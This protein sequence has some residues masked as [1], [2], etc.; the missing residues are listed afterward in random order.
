MKYFIVHRPIYGMSL[1]RSSA[2]NRLEHLSTPFYE[3]ICK[4]VLY[5]DSSGYYNH[6]VDD[7]LANWLTQVNNLTIKGN[8]KLKAK[9]YLNSFLRDFGD[10]YSDA[11]INLTAFALSNRGKYPAVRTDSYI[12]N[13]YE[14]SQSII[15]E[16]PSILASNNSLNQ[17]DF[18]NIL[19]DLLDYQCLNNR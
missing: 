14:V 7:E 10:D 4:C 1:D 8:K 12:T 9:D 18:I 3:H 5:G 16:L 19:H 6:W 15:S 2:I 13:M 11:R 17:R